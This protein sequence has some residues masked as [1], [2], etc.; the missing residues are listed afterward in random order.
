LINPQL[1]STRNEGIISNKNRKIFNFFPESPKKASLLRTSTH[2][3]RTKLLTSKEKLLNNSE[4]MIDLKLGIPLPQFLKTHKAELLDCEMS[5]VLNYRKIYFWGQLQVKMQR[6]AKY[7]KFDDENGNLILFKH[8][9]I[10][11]RY[12]IVKILG[13]G[14]FGQV[15]ECIDH[16]DD[17]KVAV[18]IVKS[19]NNFK[20]QAESEIKILKFISETS[21][22]L[23][24]ICMKESFSFRGHVCIVMELLGQNLYELQQ[25]KNFSKFSP[26]LLKTFAVQ[27]LNALKF[28][29]EF[30]IIHCDLKL[31]NILL[32]RNEKNSL[33]IIDFGSSCFVHE[34]VFSYI[35]SRY[36]RAPEV[37]LNLN[38]NCAIDIW[39]FG[40]IMVELA[41][42]KPLF[43]AECERELLQLMMQ[44]KG[45][46][47]EEMLEKSI[48]KNKFFSQ[49]L[50]LPDK[51]GNIL[52]PGSKK[53]EEIIEGETI[54]LDF[55]E[56]CLE[57]DPAF[58]MTAQ[59]ALDHPWLRQEE[60]SKKAQILKLLRRS[61]FFKK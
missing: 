38:Y 37:V 11:F 1:R 27:I 26:N 10:A 51:Y 39:S 46:V 36:Y 25:S 7:K 24:V 30:K 55:I 52:Q 28:F 16:K 5:E 41:S 35:Q 43:P 53:L 42:G 14:S 33:K 56:G 19:A 9:H 3:K 22:N 31:E 50:I 23:P 57:W 20:V 29:H 60:K 45:R 17:L 54:F 15:C 34:K 4:P 12:E 61:K 44:V 21:K 58:R 6:T 18:K 8:D 49:G 13:F 32:S 48:K 40:C 47:P 59:Q 2:S